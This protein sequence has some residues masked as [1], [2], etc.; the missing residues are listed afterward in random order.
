MVKYPVFQDTKFRGLPQLN[1]RGNLNFL[2]KIEFL[3]G[4]VN[5]ES[6]QSRVIIVFHTGLKFTQPK[7]DYSFSE[8]LRFV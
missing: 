8:M 6:I 7:Q 2:I 5:A 4:E 3:L 1:C